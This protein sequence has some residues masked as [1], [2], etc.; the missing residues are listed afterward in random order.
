[1][2]AITTRIADGYYRVVD[3]A[4][5]MAVEL[6]DG[7]QGG[8]IRIIDQSSKVQGGPTPGESYSHVTEGAQPVQV[9][10]WE[11]RPS[12]E[13]TFFNQVWLINLVHGPD[14]FKLTN[15]RGGGVLELPDGEN[16]PA[17]QGTWDPK[18]PS[19]LW[20]IDQ[21]GDGYS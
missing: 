17:Q 9:V 10:S 14:Q 4:Y 18:L 12:S 2:S 8:P 1:M 5:Q 3:T 20:R 11:K 6:K 16:V 7:S 19:Q 13:I 21:S 15:V